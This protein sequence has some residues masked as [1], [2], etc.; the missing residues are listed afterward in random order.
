S[1]PPATRKSAPPFSL[2]ERL[3]T[4]LAEAAALLAKLEPQDARSRLL[5]IAMLRRD[6][7]LLDGILAELALPAQ[8][9]RPPRPPRRPR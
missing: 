5:H 6:E 1:V 7:A 9:P 8:P 2:A 3:E 4:K